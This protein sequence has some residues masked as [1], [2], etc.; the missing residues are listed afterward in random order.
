MRDTGEGGVRRMR[1]LL[2][3]DEM[4]LF[5][6]YILDTT[7]LT[8]PGLISDSLFQPAWRFFWKIHDFCWGGALGFPPTFSRCLLR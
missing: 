5:I 7:G 4:S 8:H 1:G 2:D 3:E 6:E